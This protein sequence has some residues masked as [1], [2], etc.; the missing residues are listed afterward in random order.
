MLTWK[1]TAFYSY[2]LHVYQL[3]SIHFISVGNLSRTLR[4]YG[5][6]AVKV[7]GFVKVIKTQ[8]GLFPPPSI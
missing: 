4:E 1:Q 2:T 5:A 6:V 7:N 3:S 8:M